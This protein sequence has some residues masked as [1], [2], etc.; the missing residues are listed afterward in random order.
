MGITVSLGSLLG[1]VS[2][3]LLRLPLEGFTY[4]FK[5]KISM[6]FIS[7][8][9][10]SPR[11]QLLGFEE[12]YTNPITVFSTDSITLKHLDLLQEILYK[13]IMLTMIIRENASEVLPGQF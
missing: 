10:K 9:Q 2:Q 1:C 11:I 12:G 5:V 13:I 4:I 8:P 6:F 7:Q 3:S